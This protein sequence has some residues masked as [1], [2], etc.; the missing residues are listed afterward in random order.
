ESRWVQAEPRGPALAII[1]NA[2]GPGVMA[3][4][5]LMLDGGQLA[6]LRPET[7]AALDAVLPPFW[8]HANPI[9]ILGDATPER[10]RQVVEICAKDDRIDG[11]LVLLTPQAM[12]DPTETARQL[13]SLGPLQRKPMLA[14]WMG[15]GAVRASRDILDRASIPT[16]YA[17][18]L[19]IRAFQHMYR[20]RRNQELLYETPQAI[21][22]DVNPD[23]KSVRSLFDALR[24]EGRTL[25]TEAEAKEVLSAYG[26]PVTPTVPCRSVEEAVA[27]AGR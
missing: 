15:G 7:R 22:E 3:A 27:A 18:E 14:C 5:A 2:G 4:D 21:A 23:P 19:A 26:I 9:D 10:Y 16:F 17:P 20:P 11:L 25:L 8:S 13:A 1:T 6:E 12:T 24:A